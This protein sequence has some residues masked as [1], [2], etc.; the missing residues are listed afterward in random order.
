MKKRILTMALSALISG[1]MLAGPVMAQG[2]SGF[3][4]GGDRRAQTPKRRLTRLLQNIEELEKA[5]KAPLTKPQAKTIVTV[6]SPWKAK[7]K[8]SDDEAKAIYGKVNGALTTKQKN[9]I[10]KIAALARRTGGG[11]NWGGGGGQ[12]GQG[13][14]Q[15]GP[16]DAARM[17]EMRQRMQKMQGF[18]KTYNPFYPPTKYAE[19]K[20]IPERM[21][22]RMTKS[23]QARISLLSKLAAKAK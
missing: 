12:G 18:M 5:K 21:Q 17:A 19:F 3:G 20:S 2:G 8:M 13:G 22:E 11:G 6:L 9:E 23:Y 10:D 4:G 15:G 7:T 14:G 1:A 16:P